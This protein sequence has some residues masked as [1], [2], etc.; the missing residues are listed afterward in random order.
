MVPMKIS[1]LLFGPLKMGI[2]WYESSNTNTE[3]EFDVRQNKLDTYREQNIE[4]FA[5]GYDRSHHIADAL[6]LVEGLG[7]GEKSDHT[8]QICD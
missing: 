6:T 3:S 8:V 5:Y 4:P 7:A 1:C 2:I